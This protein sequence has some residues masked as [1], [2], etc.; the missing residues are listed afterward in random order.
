MARHW[1]PKQSRFYIFIDE[2]PDL[3]RCGHTKVI[4]KV[5]EVLFGHFFNIGVGLGLLNLLYD[6]LESLGVVHSQVSEHLTVDLDTSL[7]DGT[8]EL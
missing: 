4:K 5:S 3:T 6:S 8:H 1:K 7:V 2:S